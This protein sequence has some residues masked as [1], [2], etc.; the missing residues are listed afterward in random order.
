MKEERGNRIFP[1]TDKSLDVLNVFEKALKESKIKIKFGADV[2]K[3]NVEDNKIVGITYKDEDGISKNLMADKVI[4]ATGGNTYT[5]TGSN[6][7]G[8][9]L[10]K[11]L[12]HTITKVRPS[13]VPITAQ[14]HDLTVCKKLQGLSLK[15]VGIK[16]INSDNKKSIYEDFGEMIFTHFGI[17]GPTILH[18]NSLFHKEL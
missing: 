2:T 3:I 18:R 6:G 15:N 8:Y 13:L 4:L 17:S 11:E 9:E 12:G 1:T 5:S 14:G 10:A 7:E 16:F